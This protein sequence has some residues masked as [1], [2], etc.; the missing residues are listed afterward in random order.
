VKR[1]LSLQFLNLRHSIGLLGRVIRPSQ[2]RY[3][4]QTSM[5]R[6]GFERTI[7]SFE[8]K[9]TVHDLDRVAIVISIVPCGLRE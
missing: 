9:K 8:R 2:G 5:P 1:F 4:T 6:V 3:L 7:P